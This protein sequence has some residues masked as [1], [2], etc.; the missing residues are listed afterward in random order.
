MPG[1][2]GSA[3]ATFTN[4]VLSIAA[5]GCG[6]RRR[7]A[8]RSGNAGVAR[9]AGPVAILRVERSG[10]RREPVELCHRRC[11]GRRAWLHAGRHQRISCCVGDGRRDHPQFQPHDR[12]RHQCRHRLTDLNTAAGGTA[13][14][15]LDANGNMTVTPAG[16]LCGRAAR[17][18]ERHDRARGAT[19]VS[20]SQFFGLGT[21]MRQNQAMGL[22]VR[23]DIA[24]N[25]AKMALAQLDLSPTTVVG[26]TV[27]GISDNRG[28]LGLGGGC[29][30]RHHH[31][32]HGGLAG[33]SMSISDYTA[34]HGRRQV[35]F[36][37]LRRSPIASF[38]Q[39]VSEEATAAPV[40]GRGRQ[41]R[42]RIGEHDDL[43]A[44]LQRFGA[45]DDN[46]LQEMY[47]TLLRCR[48][49]NR[50]QTMI[51]TRRFMDDYVHTRCSTSTRASKRARV[52]RRKCRS[53][54]ARSAINSPMSK[55][56]A[57]VL[58]AAKI[59]RRRRRG[60]S[61]SRRTKC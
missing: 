21:A 19:G 35:G 38:R 53:P 2:A 57:S 36:D 20:L 17:S 30:N 40:D 7:A 14:F 6:R 31:A 47:D 24:T 26:D 37:E 12:R 3:T 55:D 18:G 46:G 42:R 23:S 51:R 15:A 52:K 28:A 16:G 60:L 34:R 9:R 32:R 61:R 54:R 4:G 11:G 39:D 1:L 56:K 13:V 44:S 22:A 25:S 5:A 48:L 50:G 27:L 43:S 58:A 8:A 33:G 45:A 10:Q 59:K 29:A 41:S 49:R